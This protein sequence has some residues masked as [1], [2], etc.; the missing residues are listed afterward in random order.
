MLVTRRKNIFLYFFIELKTS[1]F[2]VFYRML[3]VRKVSSVFRFSHFC[4]FTDFYECF[5]YLSLIVQVSRQ[6]FRMFSSETLR[7]KIG[8]RS[9]RT[10]PP[11]HVR[12]LTAV[13]L[14]TRKSFML[15][16][17]SNMWSVRSR[18]DSFLKRSEASK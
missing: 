13:L 2:L 11:A 3:C 16:F 8:A 6:L 4:F 10:D 9:V 15:R 5:N 1:I 7:G 17:C 12:R 14:K 18:Y